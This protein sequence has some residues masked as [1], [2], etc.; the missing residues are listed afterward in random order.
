MVDH[1]S[2]WGLHERFQFET[3]LADVQF[4]W[5]PNPM[6]GLDQECAYFDVFA[7]EIGNRA[8]RAF[9]DH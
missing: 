3:T 4:E 2:E 5:S 1:L 8:P 9:S 7:F 6:T